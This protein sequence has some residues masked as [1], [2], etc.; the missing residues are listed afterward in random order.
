MLSHTFAAMLS[1]EPSLFTR[2]S[3]D[4]PPVFCYA[5]YSFLSLTTDPVGSLMPLS[6]P[7]V[8]ALD[9]KSPM[10]GPTAQV[11]SPRRHLNIYK[12]RNE[13]VEVCYFRW[14]TS[15]IPAL[16]MLTQW[17]WAGT[18]GTGK[19][20]KKAQELWEWAEPS[21]SPGGI[22]WLSP[23]LGSDFKA[24][25]RKPVKMCRSLEVSVAAPPHLCPPPPSLVL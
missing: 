15:S 3:E 25:Q 11:W 6:A 2:L 14:D 10:R 22:A 17:R 19:G 5:C 9:S 1:D 4:C 12:K 13:S 16:A 20:R 7:L 18:L 23:L 24:L 8:L 21:P